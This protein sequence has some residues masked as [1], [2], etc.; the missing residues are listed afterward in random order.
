MS[1]PNFNGTQSSK[2]TRRKAVNVETPYSPVLDCMRSVDE[3]V[4]VGQDFSEFFGFIRVSS[5]PQCSIPI[6]V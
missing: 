5:I 3:Q 4:R 2:V 6:L 1:V